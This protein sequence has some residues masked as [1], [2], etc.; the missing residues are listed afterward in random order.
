[1]SLVSSNRALEV[2]QRIESALSR[3]EG[4][5]TE[6]EPVPIWIDQPL[7]T[8]YIPADRLPDTVID[9]WR[10]AAWDAARQAGGIDAIARAIDVDPADTRALVIRVSEKL[11]AQPIEDLRID[12]EDGYGYRSDA[13]EDA[14]ADR[15][16]VISA[17]VRSRA[18]APSRIGLRIK[19]LDR[20]GAARGV[21]TLRRYLRSFLDAAGTDSDVSALRITLAKVMHGTQVTV[22]DE[23]CRALEVEHGLG[24]GS[25]GIELQVEVPHIIGGVSPETALIEL[26]AHPRVRA[27]HFGTYDYTSAQGILPS[28]QRSTHPV[29]RHATRIMQVAAASNGIEACD[30]SLNRLPTGTVEQQLSAWSAHA[31]MVRD[32]LKSGLPQGWDLHPAQLITRYLAGFG[33]LQAEVPDARRRLRLA[34]GLDALSGSGAGI[35]DEPATLRM[36]GAVLARAIRRGVTTAEDLGDGL[37]PEMVERIALAGRAT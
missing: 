32:G 31:D 8:V 35:L 21:R 16:G 17:A 29:S 36:L 2:E 10:D 30:G 14:E 11:H 34:A 4:V 37:T 27:L 25:L 15:A 3:L 13:E 5:N 12:F 6:F 33:V 19:P 20:R 28:D 9:D 26:A 22:L 7:H 18:G 24:A 1:M 23:V